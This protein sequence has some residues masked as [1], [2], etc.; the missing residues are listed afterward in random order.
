MAIE[1]RR[2]DGKGTENVWID[3]GFWDVGCDF[4]EYLSVLG[5]FC[6]V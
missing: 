1:G 2:F 6:C 3:Q 5:W 4:Y